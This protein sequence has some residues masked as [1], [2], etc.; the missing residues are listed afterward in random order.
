MTLWI[1]SWSQTRPMPGKAAAA[2]SWRPA[3]WSQARRV[4]VEQ[5][6]RNLGLWARDARMR[7][8]YRAAIDLLQQSAEPRN[9][10]LIFELRDHVVSL[11]RLEANHG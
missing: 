10:A 4:L 3:P 11:T 8:E 2:G 9:G 5:L 1:A 7:G 6:Q